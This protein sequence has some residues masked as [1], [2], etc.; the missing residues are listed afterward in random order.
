[1]TNKEI[2]EELNEAKK[3]YKA[4]KY[5]EALTIYER[6]Y[7]ESPEA[8]NNWDRI[9]YS[10]SLYQL[11][12]KDAYDEDKLY[13]SAELVTELVRQDDLNKR[14]VCAYTQTVFKVLDQLYAENDYYDLLAWLDKINPEL[15]DQ[16]R[17][18]T[19]DRVY[20]SKKE[21]YYD[22]A[23][24]AYF[25][26]EDYEKCIETSKEALESLDVFTN[27]SDI[28]YN[29]RI[30]KSYRE[31]LDNSEALRYLE[32]VAKVKKDWFVQKEIAENYYVLGEDE[33]AQ[34]YI[35]EAVLTNDPLTIKVNLYHLAYKILKEINPELALKHAELF[36]AIKLE[37]DSKVPDDI[38]ELLID[39]ETLDKNALESEIRQYWTMYKFKDQELKNGTV[40]RIFEHGRSGFITSDDDESVYFNVSEYKGDDLKVGDYVSF[41]TEKSF[42]KSKNRESTRAVNIR[43]AL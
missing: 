33:K 37:N 21:K 10:W 24:K 8:L 22:Y 31:L 13:E 1:M 40:T 15:L 42:D 12:I 43:S 2:R 39:E 4:K 34:D 7:N 25:E 38:E 9:F 32:E 17:F 6:H 18:E 29:W 23:T 3:L 16:K 19:E 36:C 41:Y 26:V 35:C 11:Y 20:R 30:A 27:N 5:D 14:P 28:W